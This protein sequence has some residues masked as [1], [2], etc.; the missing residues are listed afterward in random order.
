MKIKLWLKRNQILSIR[1][2]LM[3]TCN[4]SVLVYSKILIKILRET[5]HKNQDRYD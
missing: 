3:T 5:F 4:I 1:F 2:I